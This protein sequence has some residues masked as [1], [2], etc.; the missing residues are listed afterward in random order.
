MRV[1]SRGLCLSGLFATLL[2]FVAALPFNAQA[3]A[4]PA[5]KPIRLVIPF[6]AGGA[7]D[8][9]ARQVAQRLGTTLG[10]QVVV[11]NKPGAGGAIGSDIVAK[12][13]ADG[14]TLLM[15]TSST[16]SI[17]PVLSAKMPYDAV[18][19]FA[20]IVHVANAPSVLVVGQGFPANT[21]RELIDLLK[22]NPGKYNYGSSGIGTYPHL[23]AEMFK[24]R[25]GGLFAVHIPY[26]GTGLVITDLVAGQVSFLMDSIVSAQTH[27]K[28]GK[29]RP[30][31]VSGVR[32]SPTLPNVPTFK[33]IGVN[34][35]DF[36]NWF[37]LFAP[38]G[39]PPDVLARINR[40]INAMVKAPDFVEGLDK[41][42]A[43]PVGGSAEQFAKTYRDEMEGWRTL[44]QRAG[45]KPE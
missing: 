12:A 44:I 9:I 38:A 25:A 23:S 33:E 28:G 19:D 20:P 27:I 5:A 16:H 43:E 10:Q 6:P 11:D 17:G 29:V 3:Q 1:F 24:W 21:A 35:M 14:Y 7:T 39:T 26:R 34:G 40:E 18:K 4:W 30:L 22:R 2:A 36:G 42:G 15:A 45:I 32:R 31:A 13:P 37:G 8:I 41:L